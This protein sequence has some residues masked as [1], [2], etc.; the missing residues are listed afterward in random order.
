MDKGR[1]VKEAISC[2]IFCLGAWW[3]VETI[4]HFKKYG[5]GVG[6]ECVGTVVGAFG[7]QVAMIIIGGYFLYKD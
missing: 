7:I 4:P 2:I 1:K 6:I 3:L 5:C